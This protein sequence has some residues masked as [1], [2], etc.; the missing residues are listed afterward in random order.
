MFSRTGVRVGVELA[1]VQVSSPV[2][3]RQ[4]CLGIGRALKRR[5]RLFYGD[6]QCSQFVV[7]TQ[8]LFK[9]AT[10]RGDRRF[11]KR[12]G[13]QKQQSSQGAPSEAARRSESIHACHF[14]ETVRR[15]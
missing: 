2:A 3:L 12:E 15:A 4:V 1:Q 14:P 6:I 13:G 8:L 10:W 7:A 11:D 5:I 9:Q